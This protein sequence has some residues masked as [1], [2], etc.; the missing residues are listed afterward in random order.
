MT[1]IT[2]PFKVAYWSTT[3]LCF[4]MVG[5][6]K[7]AMRM[8]KGFRKW[9]QKVKPTH[10]DADFASDKVLKDGGHFDAEGWLV[11]VVER[12]GR[13]L[14]WR[15]RRKRVFTARE[16]CA[17]GMAPRR[18]GKTQTAIAQLLELA[19]R[20]AK[21]DVLIVDPA[22]DIQIATQA[23]YEAAGYR[24]IVLNFID[25]RGS[26]TYD[27]LSYLRP[28]KFYDFDRQIDHLCQLIM[29]DDATTRE[30][31]FQEFA[32]ILL[33][34]TMAYLMKD[35][36]DDATL[37]RAVELLTTDSKARNAMFTDMRKSPDPI[38]RQAV[39]AFDEAGDKER[40][41]FSTTM[42]RKLKV[43]LR[44]SVKALTATGEVDPQGAIIRGW[45]WENIYLA[46]TPTAIYIRTG[47]GTD[48]GAAA[49]LMLGNAINT[50]RYMF[51]EGMTKFKRDLR[52]LVD[53]A[54]TI[55]NCQAIIDATNELGKAGVRVMLWY[56]S[57]RDVFQT[58][59]NAKT[60]INNCDIFIFGGGKEMDA[61]EDFSRMIGEFT[62]ESRSHSTGKHGDSQSA[63]EQARRRAKAD[64][65]RRQEFYE[66]TAII[67]NFAVKLRKPFNV[68][69]P[70]PVYYH[71]S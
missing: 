45:T 65:L 50:R 43:W 35:R 1:I 63:N 23:A 16:A 30:T 19:G 59:P 57:T 68:H 46:D 22:G 58:F 52:I 40:G 61:Y 39:N 42:T 28:Y 36:Q 10:G 41:S 47:L 70:E 49:R 9:R 11:G 14:S 25:P 5:S 15:K 2:A 64:E 32:R 7:Y 48:E 55:G 29:P 34:G 33:A 31:H 51:N 67:S 60:L 8:Q 44:Q 17:I 56:L 12:P 3:M 13:F 66:L 6:V 18:T 37:F 62:V 54:V 20:K 69:G 21:P 26:E 38:V 27:P 71:K 53:E 24:V 4:A